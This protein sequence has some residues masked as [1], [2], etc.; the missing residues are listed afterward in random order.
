MSTS[1]IDIRATRRNS[2]TDALE[3]MQ[4]HLTYRDHFGFHTLPTRA[5][6]TPDVPRL[7]LEDRHPSW[8]PLQNR[9]ATDDEILNWSE[10]YGLAIAPA[11]DVVIVDLDEGHR[12]SLGTNYPLPPT[13]TVKTPHGFHCYFLAPDIPIANKVAILKNVDVRSRGGYAIAP[14]TP[15]YSWSLAP[16][17]V[18]FAPLPDWVIEKAA[19]PTKSPGKPCASNYIQLLAQGSSGGLILFGPTQSTD[20]LSLVTDPTFVQI[21]ATVLGLPSVPVGRAFRCVLPGHDDHKPSAALWRSPTTGQVKYHDL[22]GVD[23]GEWYSLADVRAAQAYGRVRPLSKSELVTWQLRLLIETG[24][25][26]PARVTMPPLPHKL[27]TPDVNQVY[28]GLRLLFQARWLHSP[29]QPAPFTWKFAR[30]WAGIPEHRAG[31]AIQTLIK[32][33]IIKKGGEHKRTTL[34]LPGP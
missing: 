31:A 23:G 15:G 19:R 32:H 33:R 22:H 13:P 28:D 30:A 24:F 14:P 6:K 25:V 3:L 26:Q 21:A 17:D 29:Q 4:A 2:A 16:D 5:D 10:S 34:F 8:H 18:P 9:L 20:L 11:D 12:A 7:P 1:I 27:A